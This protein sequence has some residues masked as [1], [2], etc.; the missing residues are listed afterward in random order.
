MKGGTRN[1]YEKAQSARGIFNHTD[2]RRGLGVD[3]LA[4]FEQCGSGP[5]DF[6]ELI[7]QV[8]AVEVVTSTL[9]AHACPA[10]FRQ[11]GGNSP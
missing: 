4:L 7:G 5:N 6:L 9:L 10:D 3:A 1:G 11:G 2:A 8:S